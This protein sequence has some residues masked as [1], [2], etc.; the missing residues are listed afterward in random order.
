MYRAKVIFLFLIVLISSPFIAFNQNQF[1]EDFSSSARWTQVGTNVSISNN[2]VEYTNLAF[3]SEQRR[4]YASLNDTLDSTVTFTAEIEFFPTQVGRQ[5]SNRYSGHLILGLTAGTQEPYNDCPNISCTGYPLGT[6]DGIMI[7]YVARNPSTDSLF[8]IMKLKDGSLEYGGNVRIFSNTLN[9][10]YYL[11]LEKTDCSVFQLSVFT[12]PARTTHLPGSPIIENFPTAAT[13][14]NTVQI[15]NV[16]RGDPRRGLNGFVDNLSITWDS[17]GMINLGEDTTLCQ[18][19]SLVL[20][21]FLPNSTY[22]WQDGSST[23]SLSVS[24]PG[25]YW[26][27]VYGQCHFYT[28]T[29]VVNYTSPII[30]DLGEDTTLCQ[31]QFLTLNAFSPNAQY[32]WQDSSSNSTFV[33]SSP[34]VYWVNVTNGCNSLSDTISIN[35]DSSL[36][37]EL[38]KDTTLCSGQSIML[39]ATSINAQYLWQ[40]GSSKPTFT[41]DKEGVYWVNVSDSCNFFSDTIVVLF[42]PRII[43]DLGENIALCKDE[44][45]VLNAISVSDATYLWQDGTTSPTL[46]VYKEGLY[47][48]TVSNSCEKVSDSILVYSKSCDCYVYFPDAFTPNNDG[49]AA[50]GAGVSSGFCSGSASAF[51]VG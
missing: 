16:A 34:G 2:S 46:E 10:T 8:F 40:D 18:G 6:Q 24:S 15:G 30:I 17:I 9:T 35:Y 44:F 42:H 33:V 48:V 32:L 11:R 45:T 37:V 50:S 20:D 23:S 47:S 41:V 29:I 5:G 38:G 27:N 1:I 36:T 22:L 51:T 28:D 19:Q 7:N 13:D 43:Y 49:S 12:D 3:D 26:V 25:T 21:A 4:I 39:D 14:F 31:G